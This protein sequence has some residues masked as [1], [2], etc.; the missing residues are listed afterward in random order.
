MAD[1]KWIKLSTDM[2]DDEKIDFIQSLPEGDSLLVIW[3]RLLTMAGKC[4][5]N[6]YIYLTENIPYTEEALSYKFKKSVNVI[7]LA[8]QTFQ[9][10]NMIEINEKGIE[11]INWAKYQ[12]LDGLDKIKEKEQARVRK[13]KQREREKLIEA[14]SNSEIIVEKDMS[15]DSHGD[16]TRDPSIIEEERELD[17]ELDKD[18]NKELDIDKEREENKA[19]GNPLS[20]YQQIVDNF[21]RICTSLPRITSVDETRKDLVNKSFSMFENI[22][23][24][25]KVFKKAQNSDFLSGRNEKWKCCSFDWIISEGNMMKILKGNYDNKLGKDNAKDSFNNYNQRN[26]DYDVLEKKL[27]GWEKGS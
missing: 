15:R 10:L 14:P 21:N 16:V 4:N 6:G 18:I 1:V 5:A 11:L 17:I 2:F 19:Q 7:K 12:S 9:N 3:V 22:E 25:T 13:Q 8:L 24:F 23:V 27:L 26:Y 20:T